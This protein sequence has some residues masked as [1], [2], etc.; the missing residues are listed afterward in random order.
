[1]PIWHIQAGQAFAHGQRVQNQRELH[2]LS[3][4]RESENVNME[5]T[6]LNQIPTLI[7]ADICAL[8]R[9]SEGLLEEIVGE[10]TA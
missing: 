10:A 2:L 6:Q 9:E 4:R 7:E 5:T 8:E 1:M 3:V